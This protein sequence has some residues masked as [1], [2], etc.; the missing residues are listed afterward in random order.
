[1]VPHSR[2]GSEKNKLKGQSRETLWEL[3]M[4]SLD[5]HEFR[6]G[7]TNLYFNLNEIF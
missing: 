2:Q 3:M 7:A 6:R 5:R 1:M 4:S